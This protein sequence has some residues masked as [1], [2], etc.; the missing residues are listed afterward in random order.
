MWSQTDLTTSIRAVKDV[1][2]P[3]AFSLAM[4]LKSARIPLVL[5]AATR[6]TRTIKIVPIARVL[7]VVLA[8]GLRVIWDAGFK[9]VGMRYVAI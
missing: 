5:V 2:I 9:D 1:S 8:N 6:T 7:R 3:R 4:M